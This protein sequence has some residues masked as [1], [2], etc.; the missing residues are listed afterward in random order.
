MQTPGWR[1]LKY[2][3]RLYRCRVKIILT[4]MVNSGANIDP[5]GGIKSLWIIR[6]HHLLNRS[7]PALFSNS[8]TPFINFGL[9]IEHADFCLLFFVSL[10]L[11]DHV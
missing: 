7:V 2:L 4:G 5:D 11:F 6:N 1:D 9:E 3:R 10:Q 8:L